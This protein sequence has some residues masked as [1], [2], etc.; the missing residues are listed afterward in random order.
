MPGPAGSGVVGAVAV[1]EGSSGVVAELRVVG[2]GAEGVADLSSIRSKVSS[3]CHELG[4]LLVMV[5]CPGSAVREAAGA[6]TGSMM[7]SSKVLLFSSGENLEE[8]VVC[9]LH[10]LVDQLGSQ[11]VMGPGHRGRGA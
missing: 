6:S 10:L 4:S 7:S 8:H 11:G 1:G 9:G 2:A 3:P 5:V